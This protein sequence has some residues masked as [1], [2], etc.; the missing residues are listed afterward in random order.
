MTESPAAVP[1]PQGCEKWTLCS[2]VPA[3]VVQDS[4]LDA[5]AM[6]VA[7][8]VGQAESQ[9]VQLVERTGGVVKAPYRWHEDPDGRVSRV[10]CPEGE[11]DHYLVRAS[12]WARPPSG[13][14]AEVAP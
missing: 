13:A 9:G 6:L 12:W 5:E 2:L 3:E 11:A 7:A 8:A 4:V 14:A 1:R 10:P